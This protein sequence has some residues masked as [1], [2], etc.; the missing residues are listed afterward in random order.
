MDKL[1]QKGLKLSKNVMFDRML[2]M[3]PRM[4]AKPVALS[5]MLREGYM[6]LTE[7]RG[8]NSRWAHVS[9]LMQATVRMVRA[10]SQ[11]HYKGLSRKTI[12]IGVAV[13]LYLLSPLDLIPDFLVGIGLLDDLSL[14]SWFVVQFREEIDKFIAWE[15]SSYRSVPE[16]IG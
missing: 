1:F 4:L 8:N 13:V 15:G 6:K 14:M 2:R 10:Y 9:D 16:I 3:A 5:M 12:L 7:N 11:G